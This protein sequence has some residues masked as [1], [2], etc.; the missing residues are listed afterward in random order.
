MFGSNTA[1]FDDNDTQNFWDKAVKKYVYY[2]MFY[3]GEKNL[4]KIS[5]NIIFLIVLSPSPTSHFH[6]ILIKH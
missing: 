4:E 2:S 1:P 3:L 6:F 5:W